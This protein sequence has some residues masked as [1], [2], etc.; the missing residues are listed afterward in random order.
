MPYFLQKYVA[1]VRNKGLLLPK[2][3]L[4]ST[5]LIPQK[6]DGLEYRYTRSGLFGEAAINKMAEIVVPNSGCILVLRFFLK[7]SLIPMP[8]NFYLLDGFLFLLQTNSQ[9]P[10]IFCN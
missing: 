6:D 5:I 10:Y 3:L 7:K 2:H 4:A 9:T 8:L 1:L